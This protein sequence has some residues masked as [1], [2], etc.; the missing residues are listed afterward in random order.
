M[1]PALDP[2][3]EL[4]GPGGLLRP[5]DGLDRYEYDARTGRGRALAVARPI[6]VDGVRAVLGW[7]Y[8]HGVRVLAQGANSGLVGASVPDASGDMLVLSTERLGH[9]LVVDRSE[10]TATVGAG[11]RLSALNGAAAPHGLCFPIDLGADPSLGGM[12]ATNTGGARMVRYGDVRA[13]LLGLVA[14]LPDAALTVVRCGRG[15]RKDNTGM[16]LA[17]LFVGTGGELGV[18][19]EATVALHPVPRARAAAFVALD[20]LDAAVALCGAVQDATDLLAAFEVISAEAMRRTLRHT[21]TADPFGR[22]QPAPVTALVEVVSNDAAA[23]LDAVL[24]GV[25]AGVLGEVHAHGPG[26]R[27]AAGGETAVLVPASRA[28]ALRHRVTESLRASGTVTAFD[29]SVPRSRLGELRRRTVVVLAALD[30]DA[31]L[32]EFGHIGDGGVHLNVVTPTGRPL[33]SAAQEAIYEAVA[34]LGGSFSAEHGLG[35]RNLAVASRHGL[36]GQSELLGALKAICDPAGVLSH[37]AWPVGP[38]TGSSEAPG[39]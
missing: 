20:D 29:V 21:G 23:D 1:T 30:P 5:T 36:A 37:G 15:L 24:A 26:G 14:V 31:V 8:G 25:L 33:A 34:E 2:L 11:V 4:L 38:T 9:P 7:A 19:V 10:R 18:V 12:V 35:P 22:D 13:N 39:Q 32:C 17:Q 16:D 6:D 3:A 28:W 27:L